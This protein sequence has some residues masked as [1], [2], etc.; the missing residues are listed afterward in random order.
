MA[1]RVRLR[2]SFGVVKELRGSSGA[3]R[4][5]LVPQAYWLNARIALSNPSSVSGY[6][7]WL[8][9]CFMIWIDGVYSQGVLDPVQ[10]DHMHVDPPRALK[11]NGARLFVFL[12]AGL[13]VSR[14][15]RPSEL[16]GLRSKRPSSSSFAVWRLTVA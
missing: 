1:T 3:H 4:K 11:E 13:G 6:I 5:R 12:S 7:L 14:R 15:M 2:R 10:P 9:I 8:K 16:D